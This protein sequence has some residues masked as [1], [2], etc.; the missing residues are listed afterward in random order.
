MIGTIG[1]IGGYFNNEY[2]YI[3]NNLGK[4]SEIKKNKVL[5]N[6]ILFIF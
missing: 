3:T 4:I 1:K 2:A 6:L 5:K